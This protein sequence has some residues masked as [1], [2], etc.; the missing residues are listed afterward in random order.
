MAQ[1]APRVLEAQ[2]GGWAV[3]SSR[4]RSSGDTIFL[5]PCAEEDSGLMEVRGLAQSKHRPFV[6]W[7]DA[8]S[9]GGELEPEVLDLFE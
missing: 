6:P 8:P 2:S 1:G 4:E 3:V 7:A 5:L 9:V